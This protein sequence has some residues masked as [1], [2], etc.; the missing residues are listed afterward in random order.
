MCGPKHP[1]VSWKLVQ[2]VWMYHKTKTTRCTTTERPMISTSME[3]V[4]LWWK[5]GGTTTGTLLVLAAYWSYGRVRRCYESSWNSRL[6][7][8]FARKYFFHG[9][10]V[11]VMKASIA[12]T[13]FRGGFLCIR[14]SFPKM[15]NSGADPD[16]VAH[17]AFATCGRCRVG[18]SLSVYS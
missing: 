2:K 16:Y 11:V 7:E 6:R 4:R 9:S 12:S 10:S 17:L 14:A 15:G 3:V 8:I 1:N 13:R 5:L 18:L